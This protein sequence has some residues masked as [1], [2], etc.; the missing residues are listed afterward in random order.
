LKLLFA[1]YN[2]TRNTGSDVRVEEMI[3]QIRWILGDQNLAVS[4]MSQNF[5]LTRGYFGDARQVHLPDVFPPFLHSEVSA[6]DG[7]VAC[8]GSM[9]KSKFANALTTMMIGTLGIAAAQN[10]LSIAYGAEAGAMDPILQKMCSRYCRNSL[11]ITRNVESQEVLGKLGVP[12]ELGAD[13]AWTFEPQGPQ[14]ASSA[15]RKAGWDGKTPVLAICPINP[16]QWPVTASIPKWVAWA[17]AGAYKKSHYRSVYFHRSGRDADEAFERYLSAIA[18]AVQA[19]RKSK[20]VF[21]ILVAMEMLDREACDIIAEKIGGAPVFAS[22]KYDMYE[23]VSILRVSSRMLSSRFHAIV[24]SMPGGVPSAGI[25]MDERIRNL[26]R[27][28]GH[29]HLL[30][31]VDEPDLEAKALRALHALDEQED[32]IRNAMYETVAR[33]LQMMARMG[34]YFEQ[35]VARQYPEFPIR[36]GALSWEQ[37]LPPLSPDLRQLL[38]AH[39]GVLAG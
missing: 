19:Y 24:T 21:P 2:G 34:T 3:R 9:F 6:N 18:G 25:T 29:D 14:Y 22:D 20:N 10:K 23:L 17:A 8:E 32:E 11:V 39:S 35:A 38:E 15:L 13:T 37:Y 12:S 5:D 33:N 4:V 30:M 7:V 36:K 16:Y 28:R 1:G 27:E 26:M 31:K